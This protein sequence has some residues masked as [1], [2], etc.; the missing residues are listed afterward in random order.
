TPEPAPA[1]PAD[2]DERR[3]HPWSWLFVLIGSRRQF[4]LPLLALLVFG[5]R[6]DEGMQLAAA[7]VAVAVL[8]LVAVWRYFTYRY[9]IDGDSLFIRSGLL[10]RSLRQVPFSR[11]HN[12]ELRQSLLHRA[13]GVAEVKL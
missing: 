8:A 13:F 1:L 12:V 2:G 7:G 4:L 5:G 11:I 9:R 3:L 6:R 10:E